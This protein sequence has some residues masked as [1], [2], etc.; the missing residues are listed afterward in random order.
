MNRESLALKRIRVIKWFR[1][2]VPF[3]QA[4]ASKKL[5]KSCFKL[6][7]TQRLR[8]VPIGTNNHWQDFAKRPSVQITRYVIT[9]T[10]MVWEL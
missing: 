9:T 6:L 5:N 3:L 8:F 4:I 7:E 1:R 2:F 10:I